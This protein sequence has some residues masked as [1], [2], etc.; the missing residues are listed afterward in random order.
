[1]RRIYII[2]GWIL[3]GLSGRQVA[4]GQDWNHRVIQNETMWFHTAAMTQEDGQMPYYINGT[5]TF[6]DCPGADMDLGAL[7]PSGKQV[8]VYMPGNTI[9]DLCGDFEHTN[10]IGFGHYLP[11]QAALLGASN[12][13]YNTRIEVSWDLFFNEGIA[14]DGYMLFRSESDDNWT[15]A[16]LDYAVAT[17]WGDVTTFEDNNLKF[18]TEY[19]YK[20]VA[21]NV[22][23]E[24]GWITEYSSS[25]KGTT[26]G[27]NYNVAAMNEYE[28]RHEIT[29]S[30]DVFTGFENNSLF[31]RITDQSLREEIAG[32]EN[33]LIDHISEQ[34]GSFW[35]LSLEAKGS[36]AQGVYGTLP[37]S[38]TDLSGDWTLEMILK[39]DSLGTFDVSALVSND[40]T[41]LVVI[42]NQEGKI[43]FKNESISENLPMSSWFNLSL[44]NK[45]GQLRMYINGTPA[46]EPVASSERPKF[47]NGNRN[48]ENFVQN[49]DVGMVRAWEGA[50]TQD[51][52]LEDHLDLYRI[53]GSAPSSMINEWVMDDPVFADVF[54]FNNGLDGK[55]DGGTLAF[56]TTDVE[57]FE[58]E[59]VESFVLSNID[60]TIPYTQYVE[61]DITH[62]FLME[63]FEVG[64]GIRHTY[65]SASATSYS[66]PA[67]TLNTTNVHK[68]TV[69][70]HFV[71]ASVA[72]KFEVW[73]TTGGDP[74][75]RI[76][77]DELEI[78]EDDR[79]QVDM[80]LKDFYAFD[81]DQSI[82]GGTNYSYEVIPYYEQTSF[83]DDE[84]GKVSDSQQALDMGLVS[85]PGV[86]DI[87][88]SWDQTTIAT[89]FTDTVMITRDGEVIA[90]LVGA[91]TYV[92]QEMTYGKTHTYGIHPVRNAQ[93]VFGQ[94]TE[95]QTGTNGTISGYLI[96]K[97]ND[98]ALANTSIEASASIEG[99]EETI[100]LDANQADGSFIRSGI[101]YGDHATY[102]LKDLLGATF[103]LS[104]DYPQKEVFLKTDSLA[105]ASEDKNL[106]HNLSW[107]GDNHSDIENTFSFR[108]Y[109]EYKDGVVDLH[110]PDFH[111]YTNVYRND[112]LIGIVRGGNNGHETTQLTTLE[113]KCRPNDGNG[114]W[115]LETN[116]QIIEAYPC[117]HNKNLYR[118]ERLEEGEGA[119]I[120]QSFS[121]PTG[122]S[123][124]EYAYKFLTYY[125]D[126]VEE[127]FHYKDTLISGVYPG[128]T[129]VSD[130]VAQVS[131]AG[132]AIALSFSYTSADQTLVDAF[133]IYRSYADGDSTL[134]GALS[135]NN[136]STSYAFTDHTGIPGTD[137]TYQIIVRTGAN[138]SASSNQ[139][140]ITYP[141][142]T[143]YLQVG[144]ASVV[145]LTNVPGHKIELTIDGLDAAYADNH[146]PVDGVVLYADGQA[147]DTRSI[148]QLL[149]DG[150]STRY[151]QFENR[152]GSAGDV[153]AYKYGFYKT[154]ED[155]TAIVHKTAFSNEPAFADGGDL[156]NKTIAITEGEG[157][158]KVTWTMDQSDQDKLSL[159][160][161]RTRLVS[162]GGI[163]YDLDPTVRSF[164]FSW[165]SVLLSWSLNEYDEANNLLQTQDIELSG[166]LS[167]GS[168]VFPEIQNLQASTDL[169]DEVFLTWEHEE[170]SHA[171]F[172]VYRNNILLATVTDHHF[173]DPWDASIAV[174][175][176]HAYQVRAIYDEDEDGQIDYHSSRAT[177]AGM[178]RVPFTIEGHVYDANGYGV[179]YIKVNVANSVVLTDSTGYYQLNKLYYPDQE[180]VMLRA[181]WLENALDLTKDNY[182]MMVDDVAITFD[183]TRPVTIHNFRITDDYEVVP[184][185]STQ[186]ADAF[187]LHAYPD[188]D[189]FS[190]DLKLQ[191]SNG[192]YDGVEV[193]RG[194]RLITEIDN[195]SDLSWTDHSGESGLDY[196][197]LAIP[198]VYDNQGERVY[199]M[200]KT[201][202]TEYYPALDAPKYLVAEIR[203]GEI[204]L[205]WRDA[206]A[207]NGYQILRNE[208]EIAVLTNGENTFIDETGKAGDVYRYKVHTLRPQEDY[209][210]R[211]SG[212][213]EVTVTYPYPMEVISITSL[214]DVETNTTTLSWDYE[215]S[216]DIT[217]VT[218]ERNGKVLSLSE[219]LPTSIEDTTGIP[220]I[221]NTY[222]VTTYRSNDED[223]VPSVGQEVQILYP[224]LPAIDTH[225]AQPYPETMTLTLSWDYAVKT[226]DGFQVTVNK[227]GTSDLVLIRQLEAVP[228]QTTH[229]FTFDRGISGKAY[230]FS[231]IPMTTRNDVLY[232]GPDYSATETFPVL[233]APVL[234]VAEQG[235]EYALITWDYEDFDLDHWSVT[236]PS[237]QTLE[238]GER[239][240]LIKGSGSQ[241]VAIKAEKTG[242]TSS[243]AGTMSV[244][245]AGGA[246]ATMGATPQAYAVDL[247]I[248]S[249][250]ATEIKLYKDGVLLQTWA[251][252]LDQVY[253][254]EEVN[255]G[256][257]YLYKVEQ[258]SKSDAV[259][260]GPLAD[261][262]GQVSGSVTSF[263]GI[264]IGGVT[265][266]L[267]GMFDGRMISKEV[268][269]RSDGK[270]FFTGIPYGEDPQEPA[271]YAVTP[272]SVDRVIMPE[273][274]EVYLS[275]AETTQAVNAFRDESS[276]TVSG[277]LDYGWKGSKVPDVMVKLLGY[278]SLNGVAEELDQQESEDGA[279]SFSR[280]VDP[281][282]VAYQVQLDPEYHN[283]QVE[284]SDQEGPTVADEYY[285]T[286]FGQDN[287]QVRSQLLDATTLRSG[288]ELRASFEDTLRVSTRFAVRTVAG[289][290][291]DYRWTLRFRDTSGEVDT[292]LT[293]NPA[294]VLLAQLP[295]LNYEVNLISVDRQTALAEAV[296]A[297]FRPVTI[298]LAHQDSLKSFTDG[299]VTK[300][301]VYEKQDELFVTDVDLVFHK[302]PNI[303]VSGLERSDCDVSTD[304]KDLPVIAGISADSPTSVTLGFDVEEDFDGNLGTV[305]EGYLLVVNNMLPS[306]PIDTLRYDDSLPAWRKWNPVSQGW[307]GA[308]TFT[309]ADLNVV[310]PYTML[311]EVHYFD[312]H[313]KYLATQLQEV[314]VTGMKNIGDSDFVTD[315]EETEFPLFVLR[316][317]PGDASKASIE[318][319]TSLKYNYASKMVF[320]GSQKWDKDFKYS[321]F[322]L[323]GKINL[324]IGLDE[325]ST[326]SNSYSF[327]LDFKE[328][329]STPG[330][331]TFDPDR[332]K[333]QMGRESDIIVGMGANLLYGVARRVSNADDACDITEE[334]IITVDL[335]DISTTW[336]YTISEIERNIDY[337]DKLLNDPEVSFEGEDDEAGLRDKWGGIRDNWESILEW[338][339]Y[340]NRAPANMCR[341]VQGIRNLLDDKVGS[342][343]HKD[344]DG[345]FYGDYYI[346]RERFIVGDKDRETEFEDLE[347]F[348][349]SNLFKYVE[350]GIY[351][352]L[353]GG[354]EASYGRRW[355]DQ[356]FDDYKDHSEYFQQVWARYNVWEVVRQ[357]STL[358]YN[359]AFVNQNDLDRFYTD[360]AQNESFG[361]LVEN[362]SFSSGAGY[363][364]TITS[365]TSIVQSL[366]ENLKASLGI[367]I[368]KSSKVSSENVIYG[369]FAGVGAGTIT[370]VEGTKVVT[371]FKV[372]LSGTATFDFSQGWTTGESLKISYTLDDND[373]GDHFNTWVLHD[374]TGYNYA[375]TPDFILAAG[376]S[377]C[378]YEEGTIPRDM[379]QLKAMD[380]DGVQ[381][382][383]NYYD[384]RPFQ[385][386]Y[387]IPLQV[388]NLA[389]FYETRKWGIMQG[390]HG[391]VQGLKMVYGQE[392]MGESTS[393]LL[394]VHGDEP[395]Y[396]QLGFGSYG[397]GLG[398]DFED[399]HVIVG[400]QCEIANGWVHPET[401]D[402]LTLN[403]HFRR[404]LPPVGFEQEDNWFITQN[405]PSWTFGIQNYRLDIRQADFKELWLEYRRT[406]GDNYSWTKMTDEDEE[407]VLSKEFL[408]S[409]YDQFR[410]IYPYEYYPF[411]WTPDAGILDG[412]YMIR[413]AIVHPD[414]EIGYSPTFPLGTIDRRAPRVVNLPQ[415][416][417]K[418]LSRGDVI[419][420]SMDEMLNCD[421]FYAHPELT[422]LTVY[423][424][425]GTEY[426]TLTFHS[427]PEISEYELRCSGSGIDIIIDEEILGEVD[428]KDVEFTISGLKDLVGNV[429]DDVVWKFRSDNFKFPVSPIKLYDPSVV[430][431]NKSSGSEIPFVMAAMELYENYSVLDSV[432]LQYRKVGTDTYLTYD[433]LTIDEMRESYELY[434]PDHT[435]KPQDTIML[436]TA[437]IPDGEYNFRLVAWGEGR[438]RTSNGIN[439]T[440][441]R[442]NPFVMNV[443]PDSR[444]VDWGDQ[445]RVTYSEKMYDRD[446]LSFSAAIVHDD[447]SSTDFTD[448][449][450]GFINSNWTGFTLNDIDDV[451]LHSA[452]GDTLKIELLGVTD[453]YG[454]L[455]EE[456]LITFA[457]GNFAENVS[458]V[459]INTPKTWVM[460][461]NTQSVDFFVDDY[462]LHGTKGKDLDSLK[463]VYR[464]TN[465]NQFNE[466]A[467]YTIADLRAIYKSGTSA[468]S[469]PMVEITWDISNTALSDGSYAV[470]AVAYGDNGKPLYSNSSNGVIDTKAPW[471]TGVFGPSDG[472]LNDTDYY[473]SFDYS[474][475]L[476]ENVS[477]TVSVS[478][479]VN[480]VPVAIN[481]SLYQ[482]VAEGSVL[483]IFPTENFKVIYSNEEIE[484]YLSGLEDKYGNAQQE[485]QWIRFTLQ[486]FGYLNTGSRQ[487]TDLAADRKQ[488]GEIE[489]SWTSYDLY[490][491]TMIERSRDGV[492]FVEIARY[493]G[494]IENHMDE[495]N[496]SNIVFYRLKQMI[497]T[498]D[499]YSKV[500]AVETD[501]LIPLLVSHVYP[502]PF[503]GKA[504]RLAV[505]TNNLEDDLE[506]QIMSTTGMVVAQHYIN[507]E[508]LN[509]LNAKIRFDEPLKPGIY[510]MQMVQGGKRSYQKL[511]VAK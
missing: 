392:I 282:Y 390:A 161:A 316:D 331:A 404:P 61:P 483:K 495:I 187:A 255:P 252:G 271:V 459:N 104:K 501:N 474:E 99:A 125:Y 212:Y 503:D 384:L 348:C 103:E 211:S 383:T 509:N 25:V 442:I 499:Y 111:L 264:G 262:D 82:R 290:M 463:L 446:G 217:R 165:H 402:T 199:G 231:I 315:P 304:V 218:V 170:F 261:P 475:A 18:G 7:I 314:I 506:I 386:S 380:E 236:S 299:I 73:R 168:A 400:P 308:Y 48:H 277:I 333:Y 473:F 89:Y 435:K 122:I 332:K 4:L 493:N 484:V 197:Y 159:T 78:E 219:E 134:I 394:Y 357:A 472:V 349:D 470:Q 167:S 388:T 469:E 371:N 351:V 221:V 83:L 395:T 20:V 434:S 447:G 151:Y 363:T 366:A 303:R 465:G 444:V 367:D 45:A 216:A 32:S 482:V 408:Q 489:V 256:E 237:T 196:S 38:F 339:D 76:K 204:E 421:Y 13:I 90:R 37:S 142:V 319:G 220:G 498:V 401:T 297:Y 385:G 286:Y 248:T 259:L 325:S 91:D 410:H 477:G 480:G 505:M 382:P 229:S 425:D 56:T 413:A 324:K 342:K 60:I 426:R 276:F 227:A 240:L 468:Y 190:M 412:N 490:D 71:S 2:I 154:N 364:Q 268:T 143:D 430:L 202:I 454:N 114:S 500:V 173:I 235:T 150:T 301:E 272:M 86:D 117:S 330:S 1:M 68:D 195:L 53:Q 29:V 129:A 405:V 213:E 3:I 249:S 47:I 98:L 121:D 354:D 17:T 132:D 193:Y 418:I 443:A 510:H 431:V 406:D 66:S 373:P 155:L 317:P 246:T 183:Q 92:D 258:G 328:S 225:Q 59:W 341:M 247:S 94:Y 478:Q 368:T 420:V 269:T 253:V 208:E 30:Y 471:Y 438:L 285:Y 234:T 323:G 391:N 184:S 241:T 39:V 313:D 485:D 265:M 34:V 403:I 95:Q 507:A 337:Y 338:H 63:I 26:S 476:D 353:V 496:F 222:R 136:Q 263:T 399:V 254:D 62:D 228:G 178:I 377:S 433:A 273:N 461:A 352:N 214:A 130:L 96:D 133:D 180:S 215:S 359:G 137:Y 153:M 372:G 144:L 70:L 251:S 343:P 243:S 152:N 502:M 44:V 162:D 458:P 449:M 188:A 15:D 205:I 356:D 492:N 5:S 291:N 11:E 141:A 464:K 428:G 175:E 24:A 488:T 451:L 302:V 85:T 361:D 224:E 448:R 174:N 453:Y 74:D 417:D 46:L 149:R 52:L 166:E 64:S 97:R 376:K 416:T 148:D 6:E 309:A 54:G 139:V 179:P 456:N 223:A 77:I 12:E 124:E 123:G 437:H 93:I 119:Y 19:Y 389:P 288:D 457:I 295:P 378:P 69:E 16:E 318:K 206:V 245:L 146:Y 160:T 350:E 424:L 455:L 201:S 481:A 51:Q 467:S 10:S 370:K 422:D 138:E 157:Y 450:Q 460:N 36:D 334:K 436:V 294:G 181:T 108:W 203:N 306:D 278:T 156:S 345:E 419:G 411:A 270:Y 120:E 207:N 50:R 140:M 284:D 172:E 504:F 8:M 145:P 75:T 28:L 115:V 239:S 169:S 147:I 80:I 58:L 42:D 27:I 31:F 407:T 84:I 441:D 81:S 379:P 55:S 296:I 171:Q 127:Q 398:Y 107:L 466:I 365:S 182:Q 283:S 321:F 486:D 369:T 22:S 226:L 374:P 312:A 397:A 189:G 102:R 238:A 135:I 414:G 33:G 300:A 360:Y 210:A 439:G 432:E 423:E 346:E 43:R 387:P 298:Q 110:D 479:I 487:A 257:R 158:A 41:S 275:S 200:E 65:A 198:Y 329:L 415:P 250:V 242:G 112:E 9:G 233:P 274:Q 209:I 344:E 289:P 287:G 106:I 118:R 176:Y 440:F 163:N 281:T 279:Y 21:F 497:D 347:D 355:T 445:I 131:G 23:L 310:A 381:Y 185:G 49:M 335:A 128:M 100:T 101:Y 105:P 266:R 396:G 40:N 375:A 232:Q 452:F 267:S 177:A 194:G 230:D 336:S 305:T 393:K 511:L 113:Y 307:D 293:T 320:S 462:D 35:D 340:R 322:G 57:S 244:S 326:H 260:A 116:P 192:D 427:D 362:R 280:P 67:A 14:A 292:T 409:Y 311:I 79:G 88:L 72:E 191:A 491:E 186:V 109:T 327:S 358:D 494:N 87:T 429:A 164:I 508:V 126:A